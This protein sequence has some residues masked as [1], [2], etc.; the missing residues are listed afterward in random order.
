MYYSLE[1]EE[2]PGALKGGTPKSAVG[3]IFSSLSLIF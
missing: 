2:N 3:A 1:S